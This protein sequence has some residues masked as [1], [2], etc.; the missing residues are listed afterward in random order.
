MDWGYI[1]AVLSRQ[2]SVSR[3]KFHNLQNNR[4]RLW[5][6]DKKILVDQ[7]L[8]MFSRIGRPF[9]HLSCFETDVTFLNTRHTWMRRC[10]DL[11]HSEVIH[12]VFTSVSYQDWYFQAEPWHSF[13]RCLT[14][15]LCQ[16]SPFS[17]GSSRRQAR[18][19]LGRYSQHPPWAILSSSQRVWCVVIC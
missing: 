12:E 16:F 15:H 5:A 7:R 13:S 9:L 11:G 14:P 10:A 19:T 18:P 8:S 1:G 3:F 17:T 4:K 2:A 6:K